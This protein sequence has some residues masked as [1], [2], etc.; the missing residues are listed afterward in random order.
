MIDLPYFTD[1]HR[2]QRELVRT[3]AQE[4]VAPVA[5]EGD[6][7]CVYP[8]ENVK[9]MGELGFLGVP[10]AKELGG[11][12]KD[13]ISYY[14]TIHELAKVDASHA[15]IISAHTTLVTAAIAHLG[16]IEQ[17]ARFVPPLASGKVIGAFA[18]TEAEAGS[19]AG[20][21]Q[22]VYEEDGDSY[23]LNGDKTFCSQS[24][25][26]EIVVA[27]AR[28]KADR[29]RT[30]AFILCKETLDP[31]RCAKVGVGHDASLP[32]SKGVT[33]TP[34]PEKMGWRALE[35]SQLHLKN[36]RIPKNQLLGEEGEGFRTFL[37][38]LDGGRIGIAAVSLGI[39]EGAFELAREWAGT[40]KQFGKAIGSF[41]GVSFPLADM[42]TQISAGQHL[43]YHAAWLKQ[44]G[45]PYK[46]EASKAKLFCGDLAM[47]ATSASVQIFGGRGYTKDF[48]VERFMRDAKICQ[49]GEGTAEIQRLV[50]AR[51]LLGAVANG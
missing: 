15:V 31:A 24:G 9:R 51:A 25:V 47:S 8:W 35:W 42:A 45:K 13:E 16:T 14:T 38:L 22:T 37:K 7:H 23:V 19:D 44:N 41:Q 12:G 20:G 30:S 46:T 6:R 43:V 34:G 11:A 18:L 50:I 10:I 36:V 21:I 2:A 32:F 5:V 28:A 17:K 29:K 26:G 49:I 1:A 48:A 4:H 40:R 33:L 27:M 3:F 39:A